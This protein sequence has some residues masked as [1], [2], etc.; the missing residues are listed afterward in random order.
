[1]ES[2]EKL[3]IGHINKRLN[4]KE[5]TDIEITN[6]RTFADGALLA[7]VSYTWRLNAWTK[8]AEHK[9][10]I[11]IYKNEEWHSPLFF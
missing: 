8:R 10:V 5:F 6:I 3:L 4:E 9:D 1:M 2:K 11:F 7:D